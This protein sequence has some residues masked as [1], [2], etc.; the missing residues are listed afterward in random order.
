MANAVTQLSDVIVPDVFE[1]YIRVRTTEL[2]AVFQSGIVRPDA[3]FAKLIQG[4]GKTFTLPF[5]NDLAS[6]EPNISSDDPTSSS[7][8]KKITASSDV[9]VGHHRNQSWSAADLVSA[10]AGDD[11]MKVI[12]DRVAGYWARAYQEHL[13]ASV[14]GV[15]ADNVANDSGDMVYSIATDDAAAVTDAERISATAVIETQQTMGDAGA[16][17]AGI[18]L[19]SVPYS[20]LRKLNLIDFIPDARGE[21]NIPTYLGMRVIVDDGLP[22][23]AGTNRITYWTVL[24]GAGAFGWGEGRSRVPV[25][26][27]RDPDA[28]DGEGVEFLFTRKQY[29]LHPRGIKFTNT[30]VAGQSPTNTE[31]E[32]ADNWDRVYDRKLV[33]IA[34]LKTNG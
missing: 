5:W 1:Q 22:A 11:P 21:V 7:E 30:T 23:V 2:S 17:L 19:H 26:V 10:L 29:L 31:S 14:K 15:I 6:D 33:R 4:G 18:C 20:K 28:G 32:D 12:G 24:F 34:V 25:E 27:D 16:A 13:I 9:G 3:Q 8:S